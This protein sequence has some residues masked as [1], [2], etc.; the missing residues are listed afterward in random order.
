[1]PKEEKIERVRGLREDIE[2][3]RGLLLTGYRGLTVGEMSDLRGSLRQAEAEYKVVKNTL[4]ELA[5][6]DLLDPDIVRFL[7]GP[8]AVAFMHG[9]AIAPARALVNFMRD[10]KA[11]SIKGGLVEGHIYDASQIQALS[12]V[13]SR[14]VLIAQLMS[15]VQSPVTGLVGTLQGLMSSAVYTLQAVVD[16]KA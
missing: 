12:T 7:E 8:T 3:A 5:A 14:D 15:A 4:F 11:L 10:H 9:D 13:P 2:G 16:K 1:M 6:K